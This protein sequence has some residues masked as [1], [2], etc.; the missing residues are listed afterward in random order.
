MILFFT[1]TQCSTGDAIVQ[2]CEQRN[3]PIFRFNLDMYHKYQFL[4][5]LHGFEIIDPVERSI[6]HTQISQ[7]ACYKARLPFHHEMPFS[8]LVNGEDEWVKSNMNYIT[9]SLACWLKNRNLL[10]LWHYS[11]I[12]FSKI[13]QM[14]IAQKYFEV[15]E[16]MI[17]WGFQL[18]EKEVVAKTLTQK[19]FSDGRYPYVNEVNR[20]SLDPVYPWFTQEIAKGNRD[21]TVL[22]V[23]GHVH[24]YQFAT[25]RG[26]LTDWRVTQG[27]D[28]NKWLPWNA[29]TAFE[30]NVDSFMKELGL[31]FGRL[32]FIIGGKE[33]QFLEVNPCGQF[34]WLDDEKLTLHNEVVD[35]ILDPSSTINI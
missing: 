27:T 18:T 10:H 17:H 22:Y 1:T 3:I 28:A 19:F 24:C 2:I 9:N 14:E 21:A 29:G 5:T 20:C 8:H 7:A 35:A 4:W 33:P 31:K 11:E 30:Q 12:E 16:F 13:K 32:D 6:N 26:N 25:E 23:N 34:G 15:P